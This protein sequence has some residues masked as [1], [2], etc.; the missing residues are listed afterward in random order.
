MKCCS[1]LRGE[2]E[3]FQNQPISPQP[4][5]QH[6]LTPLCPETL[7][8]SRSR[9]FLPIL[10]DHPLRRLQIPTRRHRHSSLP[11]SSAFRRAIVSLIVDSQASYRLH[12]AAAS[13]LTLMP[14]PPPSPSF[15]QPVTIPRR[16]FAAPPQ[17]V[18]LFLPPPIS[19]ITLDSLPLTSFGFLCSEGQGVFKDDEDDA[20][21][22]LNNDITAI[23]LRVVTDEGHDVIPRHEVLRMAVTMG[24]D[25]VESA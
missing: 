23:F 21:P 10:P 20:G 22:W 3:N 8:K 25:L 7:V 14:P 18:C 15:S 16:T 9:L 24:L 11:P 5:T 1:D 19:S 13:P 6:N 4:T 2:K 17:H 12:R